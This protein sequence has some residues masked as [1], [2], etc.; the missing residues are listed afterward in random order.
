MPTKKITSAILLDGEI[1]PPLYNKYPINKL[2]KPHKTFTVG[3][4]GPLPGGFANGVGKASPDI[5]CTK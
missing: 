5:P 4:D 1:L 2:N 3:E